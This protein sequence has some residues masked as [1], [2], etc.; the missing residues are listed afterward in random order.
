MTMT[1]EKKFSGAAA[2]KKV[3]H[4][5]QEFA[6]LAVY[7][8]LCFG[9]ILFY[10]MAILSTEGIGFLPLGVPLVK[11]LILAK[12]IMLGQ[13]GRL[14]DRIRAPTM[15]TIVVYKAVLYLCLLIVL[16]VVEEAVV[17]LVHS[18][19]IIAAL[20]ELWGGKRWEILATS[21]IM[22]LILV[23]YIAFRE[24][25]EAIEG[26]LWRVFSTRRVRS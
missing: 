17:A 8:Y 25:N 13:M 16:S 11:A 9:A 4:E 2:G 1:T 14:G 3:K 26:R 5:L 19:T 20:T 15:I 6:V 21:L 24:L 7:L 18:R 23:P 10:K 22:L 12:F